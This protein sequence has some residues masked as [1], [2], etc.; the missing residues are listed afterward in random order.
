MIPEHFIQDLLARTDIVDVVDQYVPLKKAGANFQACCPFH[1]EKTP[2]FTVSPTKQFYHCF[3]CGAH[4]TAIGFMMEHQGMGFVDAVHALAD[5]LGVPVPQ[6]EGSRPQRPVSIDLLD[7]MS[8]AARYYREQLK[9]APQAIDYLKSRGLS[10]DICA[11]YGIGYAPDGWQSL[12]QSLPDYESKGPIEAGLVIVN[13]QGRRYDRFRDR[14]M[15]P[16]LDGQGRTIA[17]GGRVLGQGEPK[18]LNSPE[19]PLFEKGLELYGL[20]Q[21]RDGMRQHNAAIVV[22]GYMDVV[23]LAQHGIGNAVAAL[24]TATTP[25]HVRKLLRTVDRIVFCFDGDAAGHKAAWRALENSL[26]MVQDHKLLSFAFLPQGEDPDS[27]VRSH[28]REAFG[29]LLEQAAPLSR[30]LLDKLKTEAPP[31][32]PE[33]RARLVHEA[34]PLL[35][36]IK[37]AALRQALVRQLADATGFA[38][39]EI[40]RLCKLPRLAAAQSRTPQRAQR[41]TSVAT[42][43]IQLLMLRPDLV[44]ALGDDLLPGGDGDDATLCAVAPLLR[45]NPGLPLPALLESLRETPQHAARLAALAAGPLYSGL[46]DEALGREFAGALAQLECDTLETRIQTL[47]RAASERSLS[48]EEKRQLL[49]ALKT[50]QE[51]TASRRN[52]DSN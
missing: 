12:R 42:A 32:T 29:A 7:L 31:D 19:T 25:T 39:Q 5:R 23:A 6:E 47:T 21:A 36:R 24:G 44:S 20:T 41:R 13:E 26:E 51:L 2:S 49:E 27:F 40:E 45:A 22:E 43:L 33:N 15:F 34:G 8:R 10:G 9:A 4:G 18:Y 14:I 30:Y 48:D 11:R 16:I 3:G 38:P 50:R 28:G 1:G 37:A 35:V 46:D 17:F 52:Q